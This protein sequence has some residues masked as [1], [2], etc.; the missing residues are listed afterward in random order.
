MSWSASKTD[1]WA[2][3]PCESGRC[4]FVPKLI[5]EET[6]AVVR[7]T[8]R[9]NRSSQEE[10]E[11]EREKGKQGKNALPSTRTRIAV[12]YSGRHEEA[13]SVREVLIAE[14]L[15]NLLV[16]SVRGEESASRRKEEE[17]DGL[18]GRTGRDDDV[19]KAVP[20]EQLA[21]RKEGSDVGVASD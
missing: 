18:D 20:R 2:L 5:R 17:S 14:R 4:S 13:V 12:A 15:G 9:S 10:G 7:Y 16:I 19:G 11:G 6:S 1:D 3:P 8:V 21:V